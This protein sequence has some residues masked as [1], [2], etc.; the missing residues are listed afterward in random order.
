MW[1]K[2]IE[3]AKYFLKHKEQTEKNVADIK[4][5]ERTINHLTV[6]MQQLAFE[7]QRQRENEAH[8]REKMALRLENIL[9]RSDRALPPGVPDNQ[10]DKE[11][12]LQAIA[13]LRQEVEAL[14]KQVEQL[15]DIIGSPTS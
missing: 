1:P 13:A 6:A 12:L 3:W 9:L 4:E 2:L 5:Q 14:R 15:E 7:Q 10:T 11:D 8:E